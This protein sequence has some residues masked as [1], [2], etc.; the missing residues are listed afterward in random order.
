[1]LRCWFIVVFGGMVR[2]VVGGGLVGCFGSR[3]HDIGGIGIVVGKMNGL[4][5]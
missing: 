4:E 2:C 5:A 1:M 3:K